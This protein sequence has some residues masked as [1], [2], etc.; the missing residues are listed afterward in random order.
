MY[1]TAPITWPIAKML[2]WWM[3]EHQVAQRFN[4]EQLK[5][6]IKMHGKEELE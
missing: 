6:L 5:E 3:G 4:K 1:I 2:D